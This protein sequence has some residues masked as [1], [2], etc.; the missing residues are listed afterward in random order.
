MFIRNNKN[1]ILVPVRDE[2][3][4]TKSILRVIENQDFAEMIGNAAI[5]IRGQLSLEAIAKLWSE[6]I[7]G[8]K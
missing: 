6:V 3:E 1:G 7:E 5:D 8:Y 4:M 2:V